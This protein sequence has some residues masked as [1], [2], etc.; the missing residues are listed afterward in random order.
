MRR[1]KND[2]I[3][4]ETKKNKNDKTKYTKTTKQRRIQNDWIKKKRNEL[5]ENDETK[6]NT[7]RRN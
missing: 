1:T 5:Y 4:N 6:K 2:E 3:K 7:K